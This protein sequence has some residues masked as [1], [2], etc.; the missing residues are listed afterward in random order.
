MNSVIEEVPLM[1]WWE[2]PGVHSSAAVKA[3][4]TLSAKP[5]ATNPVLLRTLVNTPRGRPARWKQPLNALMSATPHCQ[6]SP[7]LLERKASV[8]WTA[9]FKQDQEFNVYFFSG[10]CT[11]SVLLSIFSLSSMPHASPWD[12]LSV[13]SLDTPDKHNV[14][15]HF[16]LQFLTEGIS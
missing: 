14:F 5:I 2:V 9:K 11:G 13:K 7:I 6:T 3:Q 10:I 8:R 15:F 12:T 1:W 4:E 16:T